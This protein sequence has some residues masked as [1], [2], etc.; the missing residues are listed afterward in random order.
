MP[1][2]FLTMHE[3]ERIMHCAA[4]DVPFRAFHILVGGTVPFRSVPF[5]ILVTTGPR[6]Q[7]TNSNLLWQD[8]KS[9]QAGIHWGEQTVL[10]QILFIVQKLA[11]FPGSS[12][13]FCRIQYKK[14]GESLEDFIT[15]TMTYYVWFYAWFW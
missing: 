15:C 8:G 10:N 7:M 5:R 2:L 14:R 13:A 1:N 4:P 9:I 6:A 11:S 12:P 3:R